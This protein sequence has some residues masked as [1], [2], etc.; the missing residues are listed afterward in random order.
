VQGAGEAD[1]K[2]AAALIHHQEGGTI[3]PVALQVEQI[4]VVLLGLLEGGI[5]LHAGSNQLKNLILS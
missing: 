4:V 5:T 3:W 2:G 1:L